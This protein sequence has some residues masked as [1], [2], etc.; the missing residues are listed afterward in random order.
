MKPASR[1]DR[2]CWIISQLFDGYGGY[3]YEFANR[4]SFAVLFCLAFK[5]D[6]FPAD[7]NGIE[8]VLNM[9]EGINWLKRR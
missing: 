2:D 6:M 1:I 9:N 8:I 5:G 3:V 4:W 7:E